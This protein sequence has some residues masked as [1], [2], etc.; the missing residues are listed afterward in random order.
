MEINGV[1]H[2]FVTA[3]DFERSR[4]FYR[5]LLPF[6]GLTPVMDSE[7]VFY[8]VG[9]RTGFAVQR[10]AGEHA[11]ER[12]VQNRVGLHHVCFRARSRE[13]VDALHRFLEGEDCVVVR[14][15]RDD[16]WAPGYYSILF[17]DPDG[18]RLELNH[19]P[20]R[21]LFDTPERQVQ[22]PLG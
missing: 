11:G 12:F 3:G 19:V 16:A 20:G 15:P 4:E 9:G 21:G 22:A 10:P 13:D 17:E 18:V 2:V 8:C 5:R 14:E 6:L 1:A 7:N